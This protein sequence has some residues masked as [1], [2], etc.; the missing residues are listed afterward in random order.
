MSV[1]GLAW[2]V[3]RAKLVIL[4]NQTSYW[5]ICHLPVN[6]CFGFFGGAGDNGGYV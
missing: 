4:G 2:Y 5:R 6:I 1:K 3:S